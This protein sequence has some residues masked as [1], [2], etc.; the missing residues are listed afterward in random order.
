MMH[1]APQASDLFFSSDST[2]TETISD[3]FAVKSR[4]D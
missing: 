4:G 1:P 2:M 3:Y